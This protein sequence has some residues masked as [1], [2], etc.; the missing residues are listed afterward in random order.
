M[1]D[2]V[3]PEVP[4]PAK[5]FS[6][7]SLTEGPVRPHL[8]KLAGFM[9]FGI[10]AS[11]ISTLADTY[12][13]AKL[14]TQELAALTFSFP[15]VMLIISLSI[16]F[17]TGVVSVISRS[18]GE[19]DQASV[20]ALGTDSIVLATLI[21]AII[22]VI[23]F[24]TIDPLFKLLGAEE[25]VLPL[26]HDYMRIWYL[27][28]LLQIIPQVG[29]SVIRAHGD[30][31]T[32]SA[33]MAI[34]AIVNAVLD[35]ILIFGWG[36]IPAMGIAG[37]AWAGNIARLVLIIMFA[38]VIHR[39]MHAL[40]PI[41]FSPERLKKSWLRLIHIALPS[42]ATQLVGPI[43]SGIITA[44]VASYGT[45]AV[46]AFGIA[47]RVEIF[48]YIYIMAIAIAIAP[49]TGQNAGAKRFDRV[50]EAV[51]YSIKFCLIGGFIQA[52][53]LA[54][55]AHW[56]VSKF[57]TDP[58]VIHLA[59]FYLYVVPITYGFGG[60]VAVGMSVWN[61]LAMPLAAAVIGLARSML[62][63]VPL[64]FLGAWIADMEGIFIANSVAALVVGGAA[65]WWLH[66]TIY[67]KERE[68]PVDLVPNPTAAE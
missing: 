50:R 24:L 37:A 51:T 10:V 18:V 12:F 20:R 45:A 6:G 68:M 49:F 53:L 23:G 47:T 60:I 5:P 34:A 7:A 54:L 41:S 59:A 27:G 44:T 14:G 28:T 19:G 36:P 1:S 29:S 30:A 42:T 9:A 25:A 35:P 58:E 26:I 63:T 22:T 3:T 4:A 21:T 46:A 32:P 64:I 43:A 66:Q 2:I 57:A 8:L 11:L 31:R 55:V 39:G 67:R 33:L 56:L 16:G 52:V 15:V 38:I 13:I 40:A 62:V 17:G 65:W 61:S 48:A